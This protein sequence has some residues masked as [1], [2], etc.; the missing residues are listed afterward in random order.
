MN[1]F[2][3]QIASALCEKHRFVMVLCDRCDVLCVR[4]NTFQAKQLCSSRAPGP[5][6]YRQND[7]APQ[8]I[9][10]HGI[11]EAAVQGRGTAMRDLS[12]CLLFPKPVATLLFCGLAWVTATQGS[13]G[14]TC[15]D[16][17]G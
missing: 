7:P 15:M 9:L 3:S 5:Q 12:V 14:S 2:T 8:S 13:E 16:A 6:P 1:N 17:E 10:Q 11:K 4:R